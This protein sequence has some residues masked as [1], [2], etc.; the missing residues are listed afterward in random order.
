MRLPRR[1]LGVWA[2]AVGL[3]WLVM[4][5]M[6]QVDALDRSTLIDG[7][8]REG[9]SELLLRLVETEPSD[10]PVVNRLL[11]IAQLQ[12]QYRDARLSPAERRAAFDRAVTA[13][14]ALIA[15]FPD[16]EQR[17][18]WQTDL[19]EMTLVD[20]LRR[21]QQEAELFAAF[22]VASDEQREALYDAAAEAL[23]AL[24]QAEMRWFELEGELPREPDHV[25]KRVNTGLWDRM[26]N[27]FATTRTPYYLALAAVDLSMAPDDHAYFRSLGGS[28]DPALREQASTPDAERQ[29]LRQLALERVRR[30]VEDAGDEAGIRDEATVIASRAA[31]GLG[32]HD[33]ALRLTGEVI[34]RSPES[35]AGLEAALASAQAQSGQG[36]AELALSTLDSLSR[37]ARVQDRLLWRLLVTDA[38]HR[39]ML[40][41][42][43]GTPE[44]EAAAYRPYLDLLSDIDDPATADGLR[45]VI[46]DR[47]A[48]RL[49]GAA[50]LDAV[51]PVVRMGVGEQLRQRG[52]AAAAAARQAGDAAA[53]AEAEE[54]LQRAI[55]VNRSLLTP[56]AEPRVGVT[57]GFNLGLALVAL[58]P[59]DPAR[60][61]EAAEAMLDAAE[62]GPQ[63]PEAERAVGIGV[64]L[65][66]QQVAPVDGG[67]PLPGSEALYRRAVALLFDRFPTSPAADDERLSYA[68]EV[69]IPSGAFTEAIDQLDRVPTTHPD[70][71]PAAAERL[72]AATRRAEAASDGDAADSAWLGLASSAE[73]VANDVRSGD[74]AAPG[75]DRAELEA[76][77]ALAR[78]KARDGDVDAAIARLTPPAD[79]QPLDLALRR[80]EVRIELLLAANR[81]DDASAEA[82]ALLGR[83]GGDA[84]AAVDGVLTRVEDQVEVLRAQSAEA[85]APSRKAQLNERASAMASSAVALA[86]GLRRW[87][88]DQGFD[89][90]R[91]VAFDIAYAK[92]LRRAGR[93]MDAVEVL[94][95]VPEAYFNDIA[96]IAETADALREAGGQEN[97]AEAVELYDLLIGGLGEPFPAEWWNAWAGRLE[98]DE[99]LGRGDAVGT[100]VRQLRFTDPGLGGEP[101]KSRLEALEAR[102]P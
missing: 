26:M 89:A 40:A 38:I 70:F 12:A 10:D 35:R 9:M 37:R 18:I 1:E 50:S 39:A 100:R 34:E 15:E 2:S 53:L 49:A 67:P 98:I 25:E 102:N 82:V 90:D 66:R 27:E 78:V 21:F 85:L 88:N 96:V 61:A 22:G 47:W 68:A 7:L 23:V 41:D 86:E 13:T 64:E 80:G 31:V 55:A 59:N 73:R 16:H 76:E 11:E 45:A 71:F 65:A 97:L 32:A 93:P 95:A 46:Y 58:S 72:I 3:A 57:A 6:A 99:Q 94:D 91:L 83:H 54:D 42:A 74:P 63:L 24:S 43:G 56:D 81:F 36:R 5:A 87:A 33:Q 44:A 92:A 52:Q 101:Y 4:P 30:F 19:A 14:R 77:I 20:G 60:L 79:A 51:P 69:L 48:D 62:A 29:R 75:V 8:S 84:A 17:P 28:G